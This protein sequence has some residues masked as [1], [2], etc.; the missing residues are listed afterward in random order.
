[1]D[2]TLERG[3]TRGTL[4]S[5]RKSSAV[6]SAAAGARGMTHAAVAAELEDARFQERQDSRFEDLAQNKRGPAEL[7]EWERIEQLL[8]GT[9]TVYDPDTFAFAQDE[10]TAEAERA[11]AARAQPVIGAGSPVLRVGGAFA[12]GRQRGLTSCGDVG[13][14]T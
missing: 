1:M 8:A 9:T 12:P 7:A 6:G 14:G 11:A 4:A 13:R 3:A 10:L 2:A 5:A